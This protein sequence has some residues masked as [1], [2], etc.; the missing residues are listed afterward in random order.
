METVKR[1]GRR[2]RQR[3]KGREEHTDSILIK[4]IVW[5]LLHFKQGVNSNVVQ[6]HKKILGDY[7]LKRFA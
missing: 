3:R 2:E 1:V 5:F 6:I 7:F 4:E